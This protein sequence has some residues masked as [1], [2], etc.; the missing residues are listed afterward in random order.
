MFYLCF[1]FDLKLYF[2]P[3]LRKYL[4]GNFHVSGAVLGTGHGHITENNETQCPT[5]ET[6]YSS[7]EDR[8]LQMNCKQIYNY[9]VE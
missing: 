6:F 3:S 4:L 9:N 1:F 8:F 2:I 5:N 7:G